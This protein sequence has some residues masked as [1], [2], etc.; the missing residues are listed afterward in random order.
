MY[1]FQTCTSKENSISNFHKG[2]ILWQMYFIIC[3]DSHV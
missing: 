2:C 1:V 3:N